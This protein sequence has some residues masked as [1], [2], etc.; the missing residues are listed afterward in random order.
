MKLPPVILEGLFKAYQQANAPWK[1]PHK[2]EKKN[3]FT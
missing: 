3:M 1:M 2:M